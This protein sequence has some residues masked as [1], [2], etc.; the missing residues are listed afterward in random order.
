MKLPDLEWLNDFRRRLGEYQLRS[1]RPELRKV[2][3]IGLAQA[4][5]IGII[6]SGTDDSHFKAVRDLVEQLKGKGQRSVRAIGYVRH[7]QLADSLSASSFIEFFSNA[8]VDLQFRP[9]DPKV[10]LFVKEPFDVLIDLQ[11]SHSMPLLHVAATSAA[12][13]K[14][15]R[16]QDGYEDFYDLMIEAEPTA[17][18]SFFIRQVLHYL[19]ALDKKP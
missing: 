3:A 8:D 10:A 12:R 9:T 14:V 16:R 2:Q 11:M 6:L 5:S 17:D 13:F 19:H 18:I 1:A 4:K 15:G 7:A